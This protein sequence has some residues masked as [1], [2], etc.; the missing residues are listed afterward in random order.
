MIK[1]EEILKVEHLVK[2]YDKK[3]PV[4]KDLSFTLNKGEVVVIVGPSGCGKS[5]F[6][7]CLNMLEPINSGTLHF[8]EQ[9]ISRDEKDVHEIRQKI[10]MVFQSYDLF[11][12]K[13]II[14][15]ILLAP[16][17]VQKRSKKEVELEAEALLE[18]VGLLEKK[19]AYPRQLSGGQKQRVAIVRALMMHPEILLLDEITAAL[20][21]EMVREVLQVV[22]ELAKE[23]NTMVI[24]THEMEFAKAVADRVLFMDEGI[25]V[26][27]SA[28]AE[29]FT[30]PKTERAKQFLNTFHYEVV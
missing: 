10:G 1:Q 3:E 19:E 25:I 13:N 24:V 23:G 18:R 17:K 21:P 2:S 27:E 9:V 4:L 16:L 14:G 12:H 20:D 30:C 7:R 11:P 26:E 22:L 28:P 5:T 15:N 8:K 29:F 6:L